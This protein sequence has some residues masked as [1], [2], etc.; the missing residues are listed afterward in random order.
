MLRNPRLIITLS[1]IRIE[2]EEDMTLEEANALIAWA[3]ALIVG[4]PTLVTM[5][6]LLRHR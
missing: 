4:V 1:T 2:R 6:N 5:W 3:I